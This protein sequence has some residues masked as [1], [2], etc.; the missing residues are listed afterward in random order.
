MRKMDNHWVKS[1]IPMFYAEQ[2]CLSYAIFVKSRKRIDT[3]SVSRVS[4]KIYHI[5]C[6]AIGPES[7][8]LNTYGFATTK[9][10]RALI[11]IVM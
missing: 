6:L 9:K 5:L 8:L 3:V 4:A 10:R 1:C 2:V 11:S 7:K